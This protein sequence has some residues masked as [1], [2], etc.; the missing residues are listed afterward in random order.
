MVPYSSYNRLF[1]Q[2]QEIL[3][4]LQVTDELY[5]DAKKVLEA[6][7]ECSLHGNLCIPHAI[8]WVEKQKALNRIDEL[9]TEW[10]NQF[11]ELRKSVANKK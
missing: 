7:P 2:N 5:N 4:E 9:K 11:D 3:K 6:I 10:G 8:D 1:D